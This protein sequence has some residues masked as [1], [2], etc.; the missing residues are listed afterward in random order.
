MSM[1]SRSPN[2]LISRVLMG[3]RPARFKEGIYRFLEGRPSITDERGQTLFAHVQ[4]VKVYRRI[5]WVDIGIGFR[6][7]VEPPP[8]L[9]MQT[10]ERHREDADREFAYELTPGMCVTDADFFFTFTSA[11]TAPKNTTRFLR[12]MKEVHSEGTGEETGGQP[13]SSARPTEAE[14]VA[15]FGV[16]RSGPSSVDVA[17]SSP[18]AGFHED[19]APA[20][21]TGPASVAPSP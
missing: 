2:N 5:L 6:L 21:A 18:G 8:P 13:A 20:P 10:L 4:W 9:S 11:L 3:L 19:I 1:N 12:F 15:V 17:P 14:P 7:K 16:A